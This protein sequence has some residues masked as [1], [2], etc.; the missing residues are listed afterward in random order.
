MEERLIILKELLLIYSQ[1]LKTSDNQKYFELYKM[2]LQL[3]VRLGTNKPEFEENQKKYTNGNCYSYALGLSNPEGVSNVIMQTG[4][5]IG[6]VGGSL[7]TANDP[8]K[9][10]YGIQKDFET[11]EI[12]FY[13]SS[14]D[15]ENKHNG[16]KIAFYVS[17]TD[18]H[19]IRQNVDGSWSH[20]VGY[21]KIIEKLNTPSDTIEDYKHIKTLEIVKPVIKL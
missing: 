8:K 9:Y 14:L 20:K 21:L 4:M 13:D 10:L 1:M 17:S 12:D 11:L 16:Y 18:F 2:Y 3:L 6:Y 19:F 15:S 5:N 7:V